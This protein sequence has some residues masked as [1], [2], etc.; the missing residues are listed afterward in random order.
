MQSDIVPEDRFLLSK[1]VD[2][3]HPSSIFYEDSWGYV[4]QATRYEGFK[5]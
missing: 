2:A 3:Y 1:I 4:I 5:Y